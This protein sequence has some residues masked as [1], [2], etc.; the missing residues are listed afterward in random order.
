MGLTAT[1]NPLGA[2]KWSDIYNPGFAGRDVVILP[3]NDEPGRKHSSEVSQSLFKTAK[4]IKILNLPDLPEKGDVSDWLIAEGKKEENLKEKLLH[5]VEATTPLTDIKTD[6]YNFG[7]VIL[8]V[9]KYVQLDIPP[10]KTILHPW[11]KEKSTGMTTGWRGSGKTWFEIMKLDAITRNLTYGPWETTTPVPCLY[12]DGEL[13]HDEL[14]ERFK[15]IRQVGDRK[16]PLYIYNDCLVKSLG[17]PKGSLTKPQ[18]RNGMFDFIVKENIRYVVFDNLTALTSGATPYD[19]NTKKD[20]A[21]I[22]GWLI[23]LKH[24]GC[25]SDLV[26]HV[27]YANHQRGFSGRQDALDTSIVLKKP[28]NYRQEMR[29]VL[30]SI[31]DSILRKNL[32]RG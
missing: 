22:G 19:E 30:L 31:W 29:C 13:N 14:Q 15:F 9:E 20:W 21:P 18:W 25:A 1:T 27:G 4:S 11:L 23:D 2:G 6:N 8:T 24:A 12:V 16:A 17:H 10:R 26:H 7:N 28:E 5:M 3:D 32:P